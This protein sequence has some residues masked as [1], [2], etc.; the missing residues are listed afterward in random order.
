MSRRLGR[1]VTANVL[2]AAAVLAT[3]GVSV[4]LILD[5]IGLAGFG[6]W[7][8]SQTVV[9]YI[10][11]GESI[12]GPTL[13]RYVAVAQGEGRRSGV[14]QIFWT[15]LLVYPALGLI[16]LGATQLAAPGLVSLFEIPPELR[17]DAE[18]IFRLTG[19]TTFFA[20]LASGLANIQQGLERFT[21]Y[22]VT[23]AFSALAFLA[24]IVLALEDELGL[25]GVGIAGAVQQVVAVV[26]RLVGL[27]DVVLTRPGIIGRAKAREMLGFSARM[28]V[29]VVSS[30]VNNQ[31]DKVVAGLVAPT[32]AVGE[33]GIGAQI[34][35]AGRFVSLSA[36]SPMISRMSAVHGSRDEAAFAAL[37]ARMNRLWV[38]GVVG[39][40]VIGTASLYPFI[41]SWLGSGHGRVAL[42]G[43]LLV[44]AYGFS[45]LSGSAVSYLRA[46]GRPRLESSTNAL[47]IALNILL[48]VIFGLAFGVTGVVTATLVAYV[49]GTAWFL[50]RAQRDVPILPPG[51]RPAVVRA[52]VAVSATAAFS[53]VW[54]L[55]AVAFTPRAISLILVIL[56]SGGALVAYMS[57]VTRVV[58]SRSN[59]RA[60]FA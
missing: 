12:F 29:T 14:S 27:R 52:L 60:L 34:A 49:V 51:A 48:T 3:A 55:A 26:L 40:T 10:V 35:D 56:G 4:P 23:T 57:W 6:V 46:L 2:T 33:V 45:L 24:T 36:L 8:L 59:L 25:V 15:S 20:V 54:G 22:A 43:G 18:T 28:Q 39:A 13:Q 21:G 30:L 1:N 44:A 47:I 58:P 7:T 5:A 9:L 31:T 41:E 19:V 16:A 53:L 11:T 32:S 38:L 42:F 50:R 37:F 17:A